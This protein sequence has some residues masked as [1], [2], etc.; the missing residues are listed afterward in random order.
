V[1]ACVCERE[2]DLANGYW[3]GG[4]NIV[5]QLG[6]KIRLLTGCVSQEQ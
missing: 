6:E 3:D 2:R 1:C 4:T 5:I